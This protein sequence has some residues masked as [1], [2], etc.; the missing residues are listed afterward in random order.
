MEE[1]RGSIPR[2]SIPLS[3]SFGVNLWPVLEDSLCLDHYLSMSKSKELFKNVRKNFVLLEQLEASALKLDDLTSNIGL[4][5][6]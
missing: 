3:V 2:R 1:V 6:S 5:K 4:P